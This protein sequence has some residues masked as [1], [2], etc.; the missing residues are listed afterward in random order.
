MKFR[1]LQEEDIS[2]VAMWNIELHEDEGSTP[3]STSKAS[4]RLRDWLS[5]GRFHG[6]VFMLDNVEVGYVLYELQAANADLR[7]SVDSVYVRQFY[8]TR[9]CRRGGLGTEAFRCFLGV[10][11]EKRVTLEVKATNPN[12]QKFWESLGFAPQEISYQLN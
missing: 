6:M 10:I 11:G 3:M 1:S 4:E 8:I 9:E 2:R 5:S 7:D 12:G